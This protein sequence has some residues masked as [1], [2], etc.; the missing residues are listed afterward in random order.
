MSLKTK[1]WEL[2]TGKV[3]VNP[4]SKELYIQTP[5]SEWQYRL[6]IWKEAVH[7]KMDDCPCPMPWGHLMFDDDSGYKEISNRGYQNELF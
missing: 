2:W 1:P 6:R 5:D 4:Q 7:M 3:V